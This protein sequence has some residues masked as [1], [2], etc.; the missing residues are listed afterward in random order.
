MPADPFRDALTDRALRSEPERLM[1]ALS[2][3]VLLQLARGLIT[4]IRVGLEA[5]GDDRSNG[6]R[7]R[8]VRGVQRGRRL[9][10][11][12]NHVGDGVGAQ[13]GTAL[14]RHAAGQ[15]FVQ[16][17]AEGVEVAAGIQLSAAVANRVEMFGGHVG[18]RAA[19]HRRR[20]I[21]AFGVLGHVEVKQHRLAVLGQEDVGRLEVVVQDAALVG[22]GQSVGEALADPQ[23]RLDVTHPRQLL[24]RAAALG[25][26]R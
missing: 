6:R 26:R 18:Q 3:Q 19:G 21:A 24:Q 11:L 9:L 7:N 17:D 12:V 2:A 5:V 8:R 22:V 13:S 10:A 25:R 15:Q 20:G 23:D 14:V 1:G 16:D 4:S